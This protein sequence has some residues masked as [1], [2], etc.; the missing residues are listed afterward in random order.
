MTPRHPFIK[1]AI[2]LGELLRP[3]RGLKRFQDMPPEAPPPATDEAL[4]QDIKEEGK[5]EALR[6]LG[7]VES[8]PLSSE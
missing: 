4:M 6:E 1:T 7:L 8:D 2:S 3:L 5:R